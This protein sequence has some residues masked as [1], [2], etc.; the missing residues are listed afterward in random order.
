MLEGFKYPARGGCFAGVFVSFLISK[1]RTKSR[2]TNQATNQPTNCDCPVLLLYFAY[3]CYL[4]IEY[5]RLRRGDGSETE[6]FI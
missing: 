5:V 4:Y 2:P 3:S 1:F 6:T